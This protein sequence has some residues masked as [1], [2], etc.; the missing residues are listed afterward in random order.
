MHEIDL[1]GIDVDGDVGPELEIEP[2][3]ARAFGQQGLIGAL[4]EVLRRPIDEIARHPVDMAPGL[5]PIVAAEQAREAGMGDLDVEPVRIIVGDVLPVDVARTQRDPADR[6]QSLEA[7]G[8]DFGV[9]GRHHFGDG[10]PAGFEADEQETAPRLQLDRDQAETLGIEPG[11]ILSGGHADQPPVIG[12]GPGMIG[13]GQPLGAARLAVDQPRAAVAADIGEGAHHTVAAAN[14]DHALAE[15][16]ERAPVASVWNVVGVADDLPR[17]ADQPL[18][19]DP[20]IFGIAIDPA[21]QAEMVEIVGL[22]ARQ[23]GDVGHGLSSAEGPF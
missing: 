22:A 19:L 1:V 15:Q 13:A 18:H 12:I 5:D 11:I 2:G 9:I 3:P 21:G 14:H 8:G 7:M 10:G 6:L 23:S 17:R 4:G 20:E 16:V